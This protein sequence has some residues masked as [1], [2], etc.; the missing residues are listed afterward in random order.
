MVIEIARMI[1]MIRIIVSSL[2]IFVLVALNDP[3]IFLKRAAK[4]TLNLSPSGTMLLLIYAPKASE[5]VNT[6][7]TV[8][9]GDNRIPNGV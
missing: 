4:S 5:T 1:E 2:S 9:I 3:F 6:D 7:R 8:R